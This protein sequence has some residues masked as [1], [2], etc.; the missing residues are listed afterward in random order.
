MFMMEVCP[1]S[2]LPSLVRR[3]VLPGGGFREGGG[4]EGGVCIRGGRGLVWMG[5]IWLGE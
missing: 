4:E 5:L 3:R 1:R 2:S